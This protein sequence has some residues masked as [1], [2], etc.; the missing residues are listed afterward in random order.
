[1]NIKQYTDLIKNNDIISEAVSSIE[2]LY[3]VTLN[4][5]LKHIV[6]VVLDDYFIDEKCR[7]LSIKEILRSED[8]IGVDFTE[9]NM[10]PLIDCKDDDYIVYNFENQKYEM[11][12]IYDEVSFREGENMRILLDSIK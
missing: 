7:V 4:D 9:L 11:Y 8:F 2:E 10:I 3:G 5:D 12:N 6:S 1:M